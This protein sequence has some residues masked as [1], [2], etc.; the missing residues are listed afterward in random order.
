M[1]FEG[2]IRMVVIVRRQQHN[3]VSLIRSIG[4]GNSSLRILIRLADRAVLIEHFVIEV[5]RKI[6]SRFVQ[7]CLVLVDANDVAHARF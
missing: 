7:D 1:V 6:N 5:F 2:A 4:R 3:L